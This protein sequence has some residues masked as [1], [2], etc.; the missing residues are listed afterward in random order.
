[1]MAG[2]KVLPLLQK[3]FKLSGK[4]LNSKQKKFQNLGA[5]TDVVMFLGRVSGKST[6]ITHINQAKITP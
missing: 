6:T 2:C 5:L 1:M 4:P 3:P